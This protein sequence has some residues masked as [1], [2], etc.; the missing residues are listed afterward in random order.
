[1]AFRVVEPGQPLGV[2]R[3]DAVV[4]VPVYEARALFE[5][6][7][8]SVADHTDA[9]TVLVA[10]DA[11]TDSGIEAFARRIAEEAPHLDV[12][13]RASRS[14]PASC[15]TSTTPSPPPPPRTS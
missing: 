3:G 14:T 15:A 1:M 11:S 6:C 8:R 13:S 5:Q 7:L 12:I 10:D 4:C 2:A 9:A